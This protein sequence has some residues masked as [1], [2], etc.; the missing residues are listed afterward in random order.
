LVGIDDKIEFYNP[1][2]LYGDITIE[3]II[4]NN[5]SPKT[6]NKLIAKAFKEVGIIEKYG[7][8]IKRVFDFCSNFGIIPPK[9]EEVSNGFRVTLFKTKITN[10]ELNVVEN[11]VDNVVEKRLNKILNFLKQ[12]SQL[13]ANE[14]SKLLGIT[15]RTVQ[16]DLNKL[17]N[18]NKIKRIGSDKGGHWE[19]IGNRHIN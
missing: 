14:I 3:D 5:Y 19:I 12:N 4:S 8:G 10:K 18:L 13:S 17:K 7:S 1:G 16:R 15:E 11:V 2:K 9:F 6:R